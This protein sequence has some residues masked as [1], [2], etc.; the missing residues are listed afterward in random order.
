MFTHM[1]I[2]IITHQFTLIRALIVAGTEVQAVV[3]VI[4]ITLKLALLVVKK[5]RG[6]F[7]ASFIVSVLF[8]RGLVRRMVLLILVNSVRQSLRCSSKSA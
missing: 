5:T 2:T 7:P 4:I 1:A 6:Y 3:A 8:F